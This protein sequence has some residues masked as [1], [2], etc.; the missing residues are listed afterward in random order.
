MRRCLSASLGGE[1]S[2]KQ[3]GDVAI[4]VCDALNCWMMCYCAEAPSRNAAQPAIE[5]DGA[6]TVAW[7]GGGGHGGVGDEYDDE[8]LYDTA[9]QAFGVGA[10]G[11]GRAS[12]LQPAATSTRW[13]GRVRRGLGASDGGS[14]DDEDGPALSALSLQQQQQALPQRLR[15]RHGEEDM[16]EART[17]MSR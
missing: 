11:H 7:L 8:N 12:S 13:R 6:W 4:S 5:D 14:D 16:A 15:P 17:Q 2:S 9:T 3:V 1:E 10:E